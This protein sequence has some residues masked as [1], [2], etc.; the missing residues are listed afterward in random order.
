[1]GQARTPCNKLVENLGIGGIIGPGMWPELS[2]I[3]PRLSC[4]YLPERGLILK[5]VA[6]MRARK[7]ANVEFDNKKWTGQKDPAPGQY[8]RTL[9]SWDWKDYRCTIIVQICETVE[10]ACYGQKRQLQAGKAIADCGV[11]WGSKYCKNGMLCV[12][13]CRHPVD[14]SRTI[15]DQQNTRALWALNSQ[16]PW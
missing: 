13:R 8:N 11:L 4:T 5:L 2:P 7:D 9:D 12:R 14:W 10:G 16:L 1:M 3:I 6:L 15:A